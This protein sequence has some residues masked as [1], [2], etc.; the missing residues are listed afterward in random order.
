MLQRGLA[1]ERVEN[2]QEVGLEPTDGPHG[3]PSSRAPGRFH[4]PTAEAAGNPLTVNSPPAR[5]ISNVFGRCQRGSRNNR[6]STN[7]DELCRPRLRWLRQQAL[8][9]VGPGR[10]LSA[11]AERLTRATL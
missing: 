7:L 6:N 9:D 10:D 3:R 11:T 8:S 5:R 4:R 2:V 1:E